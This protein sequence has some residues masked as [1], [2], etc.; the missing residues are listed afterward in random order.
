MNSYEY[1]EYP[2]HVYE[3][4]VPLCH[5]GNVVL[6]RNQTDGNL[7]VKKVLEYYNPDIYRQLRGSY[8]ENIPRI[9]GI[10]EQQRDLKLI[11]IEEYITGST[12][13]DLLE[14][15]GIFSEEETI[16]IAIK[17]CKILMDLHKLKPSIVH[18]DIKPSNVIITSKGEVKLIDFNAAKEDDSIKGRD[19]VLIGT[20]GFAAPEQYG[21]A[22]STPQTD[23]YGVGVL[24]NIMLTGALPSIKQAEGRLKKVINRCVQ[25]NPKDRYDSIKELCNSL[26]RVS[27]TKKEWLPPGFRTM[28][29]YKMLIAMLGYGGIIAFVMLIEKDETESVADLF[30]WRIGFLL[31]G[32]FIVFFYCDYLD[33]KRKMPLIKSKSKIIKIFGMVLVPTIAFWIIMLIVSLI[34]MF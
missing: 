30:L 19:T 26:K 4:I 25:L 16:S 15:K 3:E 9:Y 28:K 23:I 6:V 8:I 10:Y 5:K 11:V 21:F 34:I 22:S 1:R 2:S 31:A 20:A 27:E 17:L 29:I 14:E 13:A 24:M 32:L 7:Y 12:I 33:I 18:R